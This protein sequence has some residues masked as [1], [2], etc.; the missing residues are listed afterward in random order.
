MIT[1]NYGEDWAKTTYDTLTASD[2]EA[3]LKPGMAVSIKPNLVNESHPQNGATTH[4]EVV[5]G[6]V[7]FLKDFGVKKI[8][9]IESAAVGNNTKRAYKAAGYEALEKKYGIPLIDLKNAPSK[10][11]CHN[12]LDIQIAEEALRAEFLINVPVLKA[13]CQTRMTCA[14]KNLKGCIPEKEMRRFHTLGLHRPIAALASL[15]PMHYC[16]VDGICGDLSFEEGGSPIEANRIIAGR[17][18]VLVDSFCAGLIGYKPEDIGYLTYAQENGL[19][20]FCSPQTKV[21]ELNA[22]KKPVRQ[23]KSSRLSE[24]YRGNNIKEDA[25]CSVCYASLVFAM[26]RSG[27]KS[28]KNIYIGQ[29]FKE[30]RGE[31]IGIGNC[32]RGFS[33]CVKGCPPKAVDIMQVLT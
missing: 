21:L 7:L 17:N 29:G 23:Q 27:G 9:I 24:R 20:E 16:V 14:I 15:L 6:I 12:G 32:T 8:Q 13:H 31:G 1:V 18:P 10:T 25:A 33:T 2:I 19:G 5:E 3:C 4:P 22:D 30:K 28:G 26:H 11:L